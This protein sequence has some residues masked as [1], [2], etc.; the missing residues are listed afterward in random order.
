MYIIMTI[1]NTIRNIGHLLTE[2]NLGTFITTKKWYL[3]S[4]TIMIISLCMSNHHVVQL[5]YIQFLLKIKL[6]SEL[7]HRKK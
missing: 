2:C 5:E 7:E 1:V 4:V 3:A 6:K